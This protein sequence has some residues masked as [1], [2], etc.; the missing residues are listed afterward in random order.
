MLKPV[1]NGKTI[2]NEKIL[3][4]NLFENVKFFSNLSVKYL[5]FEKLQA[6]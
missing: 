2:E 5:K 3:F 4:E 1:D 6:K